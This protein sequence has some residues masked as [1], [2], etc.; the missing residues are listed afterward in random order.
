MFAKAK[1]FAKRTASFYSFTA[2]LYLFLLRK[3]E[4]ICGQTVFSDNMPVL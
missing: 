4:L 2:D 3:V 1:M